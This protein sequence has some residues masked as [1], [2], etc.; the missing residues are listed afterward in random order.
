MNWEIILSSSGISG[1]LFAAAWFLILKPYLDSRLGKAGEIAAQLEK[2]N[3]IKTI[4]EG[5]KGIEH[6]FAEK[7]ETKKASLMTHEKVVERTFIAM[8]QVLEETTAMVVKL[9][10]MHSL[11]VNKM[12]QT[13]DYK[14]IWNELAKLG[15][16]QAIRRGTLG[17]YFDHELNDE[18]ERLSEMAVAMAGDSEFDEKVSQ[19]V[20]VIGDQHRKVTR[21]M[22]SRIEKLKLSN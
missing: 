7:L 3:D 22:N 19:Y 16:L 9:N 5:L 2:L 14:K 6:S 21:M 18:I 11:H 8:E 17:M 10:Q 12:A 15:E 20:T 4:H 1:A 13:P